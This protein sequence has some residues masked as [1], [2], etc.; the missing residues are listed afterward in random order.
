MKNNLWLFTV[1]L[2]LLSGCQLMAREK[3]PYLASAEMVMEESSEYEVAG[4]NL[5]VMNKSDKEIE[6]FTVVFFLFDQDGNPPENMKNSLVLSI[7]SQIDPH[8]VLET[9]ICLDD[10]LYTVPEGVYQVDYLYLSNITYDDGSVWSDPYG[11]KVF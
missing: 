7:N 6:S 10:Y 4:I 2:F 8:E 3:Y 1:C 9:C 11:F 5:H